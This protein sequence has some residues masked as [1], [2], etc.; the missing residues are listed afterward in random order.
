MFAIGT[1]V[2]QQINLF[3]STHDIVG[4][5]IVLGDIRAGSS[6]NIIGVLNNNGNI[7]F[8]SPTEYIRDVFTGEEHSDYSITI[9]FSDKT[10]DLLPDSISGF[11][12]RYQPTENGLDI[13]EY[14]I[15][16][17]ILERGIK[18]VQ[19]E[20]RF[21]RFYIKANVVSPK[22]VI[23]EDTLNFG[24]VTLNKPSCLNYKDTSLTIYNI[25]NETLLIKSIKI[26]NGGGANFFTGATSLEIEPNS[27]GKIDI[28]FENNSGTV[29]QYY[30]TMEQI[31]RAS[32]RET[33]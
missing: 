25:G 19:S 29:G 22:I 11:A 20:K 12:L 16:S 6:N 3:T 30:A 9:G 23:A 8:H 4:D 21:V 33:V 1:G 10:T 17:D 13:A 27:S 32:C 15:E 5:T 7:P 18:G 2:R 26:V 28:R 24:S 14:I 31:G